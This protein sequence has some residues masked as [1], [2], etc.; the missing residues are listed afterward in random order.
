MPK[1]EDGGDANEDLLPYLSQ[2]T[3]DSVSFFAT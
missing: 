3:K 1:K 2:L